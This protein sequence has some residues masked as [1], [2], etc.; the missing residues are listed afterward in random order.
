MKSIWILMVL[1]WLASA[2]GGGALAATAPAPTWLRVARALAQMHYLPG[3]VGWTGLGGANPQIWWLWPSGTPSALQVLTPNSPGSPL[4][5]GALDFFAK[6]HGLPWSNQS[7][8]WF[9][10]DNR[11]RLYAAIL[12]AHRR[13]EGAPKPFVWVYVRKDT[14]ETLSI[15]R[16]NATTDM[17]KW[18][19]QSPTNTGVP[20]AITPNGTWAVYARFLST[21]MTGCF[22]HGECYNDS[23]VRFVNYFWDGRAVHYFPRLA[24]G[25]RQSNGCVELPLKAAQRAY[26]MMHIGTPVTVAP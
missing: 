25:F 1:L 17:G 13:G 19:L 23:G 8:D 11:H 9:D 26:G 24:Y 2:A 4:L 22:P 16:Y 18:V 12:A 6:V 14:P 20:G 3:Q 5:F 15:W 7:S 10:H 21:R